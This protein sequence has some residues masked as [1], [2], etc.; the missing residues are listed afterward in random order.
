MKIILGFIILLISVRAF[1]IPCDCDVFALT[2]LSGGSVKEAKLLITLEVEEYSRFSKVNY[3]NCRKSCV[4]EFGRTFY[5]E[6][7]TQS[8]RDLTAQLIS[9]GKIPSSCINQMQVKYPIK[10]K[11]RFGMK[12]LGVAE[13]LIEVINFDNQ[14]F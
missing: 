1:S 11:V 12:N 8:L 2:P 14:C 10:L 13:D 9:E 3:S 7:L 6:K 5:G 4:K